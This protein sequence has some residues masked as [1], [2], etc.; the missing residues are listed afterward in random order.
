MEDN[1]KI[2]ALL[3]P[4]VSMSIEVN[5]PEI[6]VAGDHRDKLVMY[7]DGRKLPKS[8]QGSREE[9][10]AH[11][12]GSQLVSDERSPLGGKMTRTFELSRDGRQLDETLHIDTGRS[13]ATIV[14]RYIYDL[15]VAGIPNREDSDP[16]RPILKRHTEDD[17]T[18]PSQ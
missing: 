14:I 7:T 6:D 18:G 9:V 5:G 16:N 8:P 15:P 10:A 3:N 17:N 4:A 11:W 1:P 2:Q 13:G 12:D